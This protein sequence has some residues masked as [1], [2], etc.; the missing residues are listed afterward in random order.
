MAQDMLAFELLARADDCLTMYYSAPPTEGLDRPRYSLLC[1]AVE[2][3][4]K[5]YIALHRGFTQEEQLEGMNLENLLAEAI[6]L[7]LPI[8]PLTRSEIEKLNEVHDAASAFVVKPFEQHVEELF[9]VIRPRIQG[10]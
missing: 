6:T 7:G 8:N 3:A 1:K 5:A 9:K 4:L 10:P 2:L